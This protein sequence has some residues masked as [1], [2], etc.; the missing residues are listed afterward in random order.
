MISASIQ[1]KVKSFH[2]VPPLTDKSVKINETR[3]VKK[4]HRDKRDWLQQ[5]ITITIINIQAEVLL[6]N[7]E[8]VIVWLITPTQSLKQNSWTM[9]NVFTATC[10]TVIVLLN[11]IEI[12]MTTGYP[13][14]FYD[15]VTS[16]A[17]LIS[18]MLNQYINGNLDP[19]DVPGERAPQRIES[20][21]KEE[22]CAQP[23]RRGFC[24]AL[25]PR[26]R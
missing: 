6:P 25:I 1:M 23:M 5:I 9:A 20:L 22:R 8:V 11:L 24:R 2:V 17:R 12:R 21:S 10:F 13:L 4:K 3:E 15:V 26:Y 19:D 14:S 7:I 16:D 18:K